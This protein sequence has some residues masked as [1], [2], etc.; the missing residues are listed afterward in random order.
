ML[1]KRHHLF[2]AAA[3]TLTLGLLGT[4]AN[5]ADI[6]SLTSTT[7][8]DGKIM[9]KKVANSQANAPTNPNCVGDN[10]SPQFS[11]TGVPEG[12]KSFA[13]TMFDPEGRAPS[14]VSH[15]VAYGIPASV[16]GFAEGEVSKE[17]DKYVG[18][19]SLFGVGTYRGPC[20]PPNTTPHHYTFVLIATDFDPKELPPGLTRDELIAKFGPP[21]AHVKGSTG[22]V[23]LFVNPWKM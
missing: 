4:A 12:T 5:A 17:S 8:Q 19:K 1:A 21:P 3:A 16:T 6:F 14:G 13:L 18:G 23:G 15:W 22:L 11:W 10:V 20:T 9:P 7:F 2:A